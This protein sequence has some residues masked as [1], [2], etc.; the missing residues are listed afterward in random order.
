MLCWSIPALLFSQK[1]PLDYY[2]PS[3]KYDPAIPTP[4]QF[5]GFQIGEWHLSHDQMLAYYRALDA[6]SDRITLH[7]YGRSHELRPLIYLVITSEKNHANL[8]AI[9][10]EHLALCDPE[11]SNKLDVSKMPV[12]IYQGFS[13][14]GNEPS[15]ANAATL[16]AYRLAAAQDEETLQLLD[17]A[18][19]IFDPCFNPDG[20]Q[21]FSTWVN[22]NRNQ[23]LNGDNT[24][25][26]Y[27]EAWP[28][29]RFNHYWFDLNRDWLPGQQPE[30][31][32]RIANF[33]AWRP[34]I[35]TDHHEMGSNS[36]FFFMPGV[37]SRVNP[38]TP[39]LNQELTAKIGNYH[40]EALDAIGSLY[41]AEEGYDD[42]Y[43]GKGSTYPDA[44]GCIG[45]LFEQASSRGHLHNTVNGPLSFPFTIRNQVRTALSTQRAAISMRTELLDYQRNFYKNSL[46][47]ARH[48]NRKAFVVGEKYDR[49]RLLKFVEMLRRQDIHVFENQ[50]KIKAEGVEFVPG[51]SF[52]I[53]L[54]QP[55]YKLILGMFQRDTTFTDSIFYD[56]SAWTMP[57][58]FNLEYAGLK[59]SDFSKK[60]MGKEVLSTQLPDGQLFATADNYA[61]AF[62]WDEY[63]APATLYFLLKKGLLVKMATK[64]FTGTTASGQRNFN[65][66]TIVVPMQNPNLTGSALKEALQTAAQIGHLD[67]YGLTTG[68]NPNSIDLGSNNMDVLRKPTVLLL[69]GDGVSATDAGEVWH[70]LDTRYG[71]PVTKADLTDVNPKML[72][73]YNVL[74]M[75]SGN[76]SSLNPATLGAW[77]SNGGTLVALENAVKW[78]ESKQMVSVTFKKI[79]EETSSPTMRKPYVGVSED[80]ASQNL[81]GAIF[82]AELDLTHPMAFGYRRPKLPVFR[83]GELF[84]EPSKNA[85]AMPLA[86]SSSPLLAGFVPKKLKPLA[87]GSGAI[88]VG[89]QGGG[90]IICLLDNPSFR[91]FWY[92]TDKLLANAIFFGNTISGQAIE[93]K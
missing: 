80:N 42:F 21:R 30:S 27:H 46:E 41:Y 68:L 81:N 39:K 9:Q 64:P 31:T 44:Q 82:E 84:A 37:P 19:I 53:P 52:L 51:T 1:Q 22:S 74:V 33:Q 18:V 20:A 77:V 29:G 12:V 61:F 92:G 65:Y 5:F 63:F 35:L 47:A 36:T 85:Y 62:E 10:R 23:N 54:E 69:T 70:L 56:I 6:A 49:A 66:G 78:L 72:D 67:I 48:D 45:I 93:R 4:E 3:A 58:A 55:Q 28:G 91:A 2:L 59:G 60:Q 32:G 11:R 34:N 17:K 24:D 76:Y 26:E 87:K 73:K 40:A 8:P 57:L 16:V 90:R 50:E 83:N 14:H 25:R 7:E 89:G 43:Y 86:Y 13:I 75:P 15:G 79:P 88:L 38:L 71:M